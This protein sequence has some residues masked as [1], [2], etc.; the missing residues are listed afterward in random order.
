[1]PPKE[2]LDSRCRPARPPGPPRFSSPACKPQPAWRALARWPWIGLAPAAAGKMAGP[3]SPAQLPG[4]CPGL[5]PAGLRDSRPKLRRPTP[6][7]RQHHAPLPQKPSDFCWPSLLK[8][9]TSQSRAKP[10]RPYPPQVRAGMLSAVPRLWA[11]LRRPS[12][13]SG[14]GATKPTE[15]SPRARTRR[16]WP[17]WWHCRYPEA[18]VAAPSCRPPPRPRL[19][20]HRSAAPRGARSCAPCAQPQGRRRP[21]PRRRRPAPCR[22]QRCG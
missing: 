9:T 16:L 2:A 15:S 10:S 1:M 12:E 22:R 6:W 3:G 11:P 5:P 17:R 18:A 14:A 21:R 4:P 8:G 7:R 19:H 20:R 13:A